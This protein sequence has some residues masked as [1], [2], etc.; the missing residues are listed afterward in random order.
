MDNAKFQLQMNRHPWLESQI[1]FWFSVQGC[2]GNL[3]AHVGR[4]GE[5]CNKRGEYTEITRDCA[6]YLWPV[7]ED[8]IRHNHCS[9]AYGQSS[10]CTHLARLP[11]PHVVWVNQWTDCILCGKYRSSWFASVLQN[12]LFS[13]L[14]HNPSTLHLYS[15]PQRSQ[16]R[17][18]EAHLQART[19]SWVGSRT[20]LILPYFHC[21]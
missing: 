5:C 3:E 16:D 2:L 14:S 10:H 4:K 1:H 19:G 11:I 15:S 18:H 6:L 7:V 12:V 20:P 17:A 13:V 8:T 9:H 21:E